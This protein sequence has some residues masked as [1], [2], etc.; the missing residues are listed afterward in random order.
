MADDRATRTTAEREFSTDQVIEVAKTKLATALIT[1]GEDAVAD[2]HIQTA[3][4]LVFEAGELLD[5]VMMFR[6]L[7]SGEPEPPNS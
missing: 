2:D 6:R 4:A 7:Q 1:L 3:N 5:S